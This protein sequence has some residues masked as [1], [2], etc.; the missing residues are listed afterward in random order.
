[1]ELDRTAK[2]NWPTCVVNL[3]HSVRPDSAEL[4]GHQLTILGIDS[5]HR[6]IQGAVINNRQVS[7]VSVRNFEVVILRLP[8]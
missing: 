1:M 8:R 3:P 4:L 6:T 5:R 7:A 2:F